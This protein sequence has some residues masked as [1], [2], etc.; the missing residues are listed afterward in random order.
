MPLL[1]IALLILSPPPDGDWFGLSVALS[2]D[3]SRALVGAPHDDWRGRIDAGSARVFVRS[4]AGWTEE[5]AL[6]ARDAAAQD[7]LGL[8]VALSADGSRAL[9]GAP[10]DDTAAGADAGSARLF[11]RSASGWAEEATLV[12]PDGAAS[13]QLGSAVALSADGSRALVGAPWDDT[14]A[15]ADAGSARLFVRSG[16]A[17]ALEATLEGG[18]A[19]AWFGASVAL[20]AGGDRALV[21]APLEE[22]PA[23]PAGTHAGSVRVFVRTGS[24]WTEEAALRPPSAGGFGRSLALS[25][26]GSRALVGGTTRASSGD[27]LGSARVFVRTGSAWAEEAALPATGED[28]GRA[29]ALSADGGRALVGSPRASGAAGPAVARLCARAGSSWAHEATLPSG[30]PGELRAEHFGR[31]VALSA[32]G[33]R[34]LVGRLE[35]GPTPRQ[36]PRGA[37]RLFVRSEAGWTE[38]ATLRARAPRVRRPR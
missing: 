29:V 23:A 1:A 32:D 33:S 5:T 14:A 38:E 19:A 6:V 18:A 27:A 24:A 17:W 28:F 35:D 22:T 16:A 34:A 30:V 26:D 4:E 37:A 3:G 11:V 8:S 9:V 21:G 13:D 31:S 25:A 7:R 20:S 2:A 10:W 12:A 36:G 15:G